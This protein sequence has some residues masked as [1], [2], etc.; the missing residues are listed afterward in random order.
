MS[1]TAEQVKQWNEEGYVI[2]PTLFNSHEVQLMQAELARFCR[3]GLGRNPATDGDGG[4]ASATRI[5]YQIIPLNTKSELFRALPFLPNVKDSLHALLGPDLIRFLDQIFLKP[6]HRGVGTGWHVDNAY[7]RTTQ[8]TKG[9]GLWIALHDSNQENGTMMVIPRSHER[10]FRHVRDLN[11]DHHVTCAADI[12]PSKAVHVV[13][14]AGGCIFFNFGIV[15]ATG[16]N[17][18][19]SERAAAA[20]HF[21]TPEAAKSSDQ[22]M[23]SGTHVLIAGSDNGVGIPPYDT[24][25]D[26]DLWAP[27][28]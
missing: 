5:N 26:L 10:E 3:E 9:T 18:T 28:S 23:R 14:P 22:Y 13:V 1:L 20:F 27:T 19:D 8:A 25:P 7:F 21:S 12:D 6:P 15:H 11:S 24:A 2:V 17:S 16:P 4:A